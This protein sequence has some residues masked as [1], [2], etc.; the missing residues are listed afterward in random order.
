MTL[1]QIRKDR[2]L[3]DDIDWE[4]TPEEAVRLYLEWGNNWAGGSY[5]IRSPRDVSHYFVLN[6]WGERPIVYLIRRSSEEAVELAEF[7]LPD[8]LE[9]RCNKE[10]KGLKGVFA[11]EGEYRDWLESELRN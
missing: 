10:Y 11:L 3:I 1:E 2:N 7:H 8:E 9:R 5:V 4:M 6:T